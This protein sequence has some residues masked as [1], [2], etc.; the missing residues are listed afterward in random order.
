M[1]MNPSIYN[2]NLD[3]HKSTVQI[4]LVMK[5]GDTGRRICFT[6][7]ESGA[8]YAISQNCGAVLRAK[9]PDG[10]FLYNSC[11]ID[12]NS[13]IVIYDVSAQTTAAVGIVEC[14]LRIYDRQTG[15]EDIA[16]VAA[17]TS[18]RFIIQVDAQALYDTEIISDN[19]YTLMANDTYRKS[20]VYTKTQTD[21]KLSLK[22]D[23]DSVY[24][25]TQADELLAKKADS[26][27]VYTKT[28][29]DSK[30]NEKANTSDVYSK[31]QV[32]TKDEV[33]TKSQVLEQTQ[34]KATITYVNTELAKKANTSD[35]YAKNET[36]GKAEADA[37]LEDRLPADSDKIIQDTNGQPQGNGVLICREGGQLK[38]YRNV[39]ETPANGDSAD[40]FLSPAACAYASETELVAA[41]EE[42]G[43]TDTSDSDT[44]CIYLF[45][46]YSAESTLL[47]KME[48]RYTVRSGYYLY[49]IWSDSGPIMQWYA[50]D[51]ADGSANVSEK[52]AD[53]G[54]TNLTA[55][56]ISDF[57]K[58]V[59]VK[60]I[61]EYSPFSTRE[62]I[63]AANEKITQLSVKTD[64]MLPLDSDKAVI[65]TDTPPTGCLHDSILYR[66]DDVIK[67]RSR[68]AGA[69]LSEG[70]DAQTS[71]SPLPCTYGI[72]KLTE[73]IKA[74][75]LTDSSVFGDSIHLFN[76]TEYSDGT[77]L[78]AAIYIIASGGGFAITHDSGY[79]GQEW[80]LE[81]WEGGQIELYEY[82]TQQ[83]A[84]YGMFVT[85]ISE[86]GKEV[87]RKGAWHYS[88]VATQEYVLKLI[89]EAIEGA[90]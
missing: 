79:S 42:H 84:G 77:N 48:I 29:T 40:S 74:H 89:N 88:P 36:Y 46:L 16:Q 71:I 63:N 43:L 20:E 67:L 5:R 12:Y 81:Q 55:D 45:K 82:F 85:G 78:I 15:E 86:F 49:F 64:S 9:K 14:E 75:G 61:T 32:Y 17:L 66:Q 13:G 37:L 41:I 25:K 30:L 80:T 54:Y 44:S 4:C 39:T 18:P 53:Y 2:V 73:K 23:A 72:N 6:L 11:S 70:A 3:I 31:T 87:L 51:W 38:M 50:A 57:A 62:D 1:P 10:S 28:E 33:Y 58:Q 7:S 90:Y 26:A 35:V 8:A 52:F 83:G 27:Q 22:A 24:T 21:D 69:E 56:E 59:F 65:D 68:E 34:D 76:L 60:T 19:E 47:G